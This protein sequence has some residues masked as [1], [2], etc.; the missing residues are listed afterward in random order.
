MF[1][2]SAVATTSVS[3]LASVRRYFCGDST[4][5]NIGQCTHHVVRHDRLNWICTEIT[6]LPSSGKT[7]V[8]IHHYLDPD[9]PEQ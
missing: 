4:Q 6:L 8:M 3:D 1:F 7:V 5:V 2:N 9:I